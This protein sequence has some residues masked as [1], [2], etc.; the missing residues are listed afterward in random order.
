MFKPSREFIAN[1]NFKQIPFEI[2]LYVTKLNNTITIKIVNVEN[3]K[4]K[5]KSNFEPFSFAKKHVMFYR[6]SYFLVSITF[7]IWTNHTILLIILHISVSLKI[8]YYIS[9][10]LVLYSHLGVRV[11]QY[12]AGFSPCLRERNKCVDT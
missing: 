8:G 5:S 9:I 4:K 6:F 11:K 2:K 7:T 10:I 12:A 1:F 3:W